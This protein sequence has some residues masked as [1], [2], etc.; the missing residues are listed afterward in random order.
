MKTPL[1]LLAALAAATLISTAPLNAGTHIRFGS[2]GTSLVIRD[3]D[4]GDCRWEHDERYHPRHYEP[5]PSSRQA[6]PVYT[7]SRC[8]AFRYNAVQRGHAVFVSFPRARLVRIYS[9]HGRCASYSQVRLAPESRIKLH[10]GQWIEVRVR[11]HWT[12]LRYRDLV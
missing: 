10:R 1:L 2:C 5:Y 7:L 4:R 8:G 3:Y 6:C 11:G 12:T 9:G